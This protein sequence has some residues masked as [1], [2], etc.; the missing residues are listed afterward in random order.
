MMDGKQLLEETLK[1]VRDPSSSEEQTMYDQL[2][3]LT[4][5]QE[6]VIE[7]T[8]LCRFYAQHFRN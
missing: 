2:K 8:V 1:V 5:L 6:T 7:M 4:Q 3:S